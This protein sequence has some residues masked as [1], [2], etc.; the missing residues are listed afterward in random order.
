[1]A[2]ASSA[3]A[4]VAQAGMAA[5]STATAGEGTRAQIAQVDQQ[6][7]TSAAQLGPNHPDMQAPGGQRVDLER[8]LAQTPADS[9]GGGSVAISP[10]LGGGAPLGD[11]A[12]RKT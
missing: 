10:S 8:Q 4:T 1:M 5:V 12:Q 3:R 9:P 6:I 11:T 7:A 2:G